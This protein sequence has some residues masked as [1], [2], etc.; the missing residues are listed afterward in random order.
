MK[1]IRRESIISSLALTAGISLPEYLRAETLSIPR[2]IKD[3]DIQPPDQS[4]SNLS[5]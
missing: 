2:E 1:I 4:E 3:S 5:Y